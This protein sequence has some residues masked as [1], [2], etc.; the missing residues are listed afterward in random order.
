MPCIALRPSK[1][2]EENPVK[3][4]GIARTV[5]VVWVLAVGTL[6]VAVQAENRALIIGIGMGYARYNINPIRGPEKDVELAQALAQQLGFT[7]S[8]IK[9][10]REDAATKEAIVRGLQWVNE[11]VKEGDRA[12]VYYSGHGTEVPTKA[13]AADDDCMAALVPVDT[14]T[15]GGRLLLADELNRLLDPLRQRAKVLMLVDA[16]F[17]GSITKNLYRY[18]GDQLSKYYDEKSGQSC[19]DPI[20]K[21]IE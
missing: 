17:S 15:G 20:N 2:E 4:Q 18:E 14:R 9:I 11:G 3:S 10:L 8:Q 7:A 19:N 5:L 16:C 6:P 13:N 21:S 1:Q 12:L